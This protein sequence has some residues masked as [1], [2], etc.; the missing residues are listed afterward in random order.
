MDVGGLLPPHTHLNTRTNEMRNRAVHVGDQTAKQ[1]GRRRHLSVTVRPPS[2]AEREG[3][4]CNLANPR[5][6]AAG[7][8]SPAGHLS[9]PDRCHASCISKR[10]VPPFYDGRFSDQGCG[11]ATEH[12]PHRAHKIRTYKIRSQK[13]QMLRGCVC[14]GRGIL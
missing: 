14:V 8:E 11:F 7:G 12:R 13:S 3:S 6:R 9:G 1:R 5:A 2:P 10:S 4:G